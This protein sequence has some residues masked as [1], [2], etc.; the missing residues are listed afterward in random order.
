MIKHF[1]S[2]G[3]KLKLTQAILLNED[4]RNVSSITRLVRPRGLGNKK[5]NFKTKI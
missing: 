4:L 1:V 3:F 2:F 5:R